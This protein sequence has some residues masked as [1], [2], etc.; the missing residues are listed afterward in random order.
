M[1]I[2]AISQTNTHKPVTKIPEI[3]FSEKIFSGKI[4]NPELYFLPVDWDRAVAHFSPNPEFL[5]IIHS[6]LLGEEMG[7]LAGIFRINDAIA[8][9]SW[10][11]AT[12]S[13]VEQAL[14]SSFRKSHINPAEIL[15]WCIDTIGWIH[16]FVNG[17]RRT[18]WAFTNLWLIS[19][20]YE[21]M[22]WALYRPEWQTDIA[23]NE[24]GNTR[25][26]NLLAYY[27]KHQ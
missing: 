20:G 25:L 21:P 1:K 23:N 13:R 26:V 11:F 12:A 15:A 18:I 22:P 2:F 24:N 14:Q 27:K 8:G 6:I 7:D 5:K 19:V 10:R 4:E 9:S 16:P 3:D 17:N